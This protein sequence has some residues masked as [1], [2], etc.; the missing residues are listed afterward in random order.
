[1]STTTQPPGPTCDCGACELARLREELR[2][3]RMVE[4]AAQLPRLS[5][6]RVAEIMR[7]MQNRG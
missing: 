4:D 3:R 7:E 1:M 5:D 2:I 6:E